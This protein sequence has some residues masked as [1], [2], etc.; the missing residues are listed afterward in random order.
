ME[1][2]RSILNKEIDFKEKLEEICEKVFN[3]M[4]NVYIVN[5][6]TRIIYEIHFNDENFYEIGLS[7]TLNTIDDLYDLID[8]NLISERITDLESPNLNRNNIRFFRNK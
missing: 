3:E 5:E 1:I 6:D 8:M 7:L 4:V 2:I